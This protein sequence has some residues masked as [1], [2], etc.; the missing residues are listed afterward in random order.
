[1]RRFFPRAYL[2]A[3]VAK[4]SQDAI[5]G[6]PDLDE[7]FIYEKAKHR[8]DR[9]RFISLYKQFQSLRALRKKCFDLVIGMRST[10]SWS[11]AWLVYFTAAPFRLGYAPSL[12]K[13]QRFSYLYNLRVS[14]PAPEWH[15][16]ERTRHLVET[17]AIRRAETH[18]FAAVPEEA[19]REGDYFLTD[20]GV[21]PNR[22]IGFHLSS[23]RPANRWS[24]EKFAFLAAR[25]IRQDGL[26][27]ILPWGPGRRRPG[28]ES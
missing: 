28:P 15:E 23:R 12:K 27:V 1:L 21:D 8:P 26:S 14:P 20:K 19:R 22:L 7:V 18:L 4:Y 13:D 16:V 24:L 17:L 25:L 2:A 3:L 6:N 11:E 9:N 10:F 5:R